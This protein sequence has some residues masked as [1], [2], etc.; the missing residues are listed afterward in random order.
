MYKKKTPYHNGIN[1]LSLIVRSA[2]VSNSKL[3]K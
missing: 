2:N 3:D 1:D